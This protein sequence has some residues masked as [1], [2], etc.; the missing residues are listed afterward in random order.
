MALVPITASWPETGLL[1]PGFMIPS[2]DMLCIN[3]Y[4]CPLFFMYMVPIATV[5]PLAL[6]TCYPTDCFA[7]ADLTL[8]KAEPVLLTATLVGLT[9]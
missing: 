6:V 9:E 4:V 2:R 8:L 7:S 3:K 5:L 1:S